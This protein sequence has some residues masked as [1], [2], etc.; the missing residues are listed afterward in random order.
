[1]AFGMLLMWLITEQM[2]MLFKVSEDML[3]IGVPALRYISLSF[4]F[5]GVCITLG[6]IFQALGKSYFSMITSF[7][8]QIVV[9]LPVAYLL[10][11]TGDIN[12]VWLSFP[13]A[14]IMSLAVTLIFF[15]VIYKK[16][17]SRIGRE[18]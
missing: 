6:S 8:R 17:I 15:S 13:I 5:A 9:L 4:I 7:A 16:I 3:A 10:S 1:M 11:K 2:L 18:A 14:E 12:K